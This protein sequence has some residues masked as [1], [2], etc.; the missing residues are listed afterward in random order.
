MAKHL[1]TLPISY[2]TAVYLVDKDKWAKMDPA[3]RDFLQAGIKQMETDAWKLNEEEGA[4]G[5]ACN[6]TG[7]CPYGL[8]GG[9]KR[10]DPSPEDMRL[11]RQAMLETVLPRWAK[12][13]GEA[14]AKKWNDTV[15]K[16]AKLNATN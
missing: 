13:C 12:R 1:Y 3:A 16:V 14:C 15:G 5:I 2:A 4:V 8:P 7:P 10:F 11:L 9:M 6:T